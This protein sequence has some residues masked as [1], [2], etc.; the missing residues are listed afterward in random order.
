MGDQKKEYVRNKDLLEEI[1]KSK[2]EDK[3]TDKAV[4]MLMLI[5]TRSNEKLSYRNPMDREDCLQGGIMD[6][7]RYWR[8]F[9]PAKSDQAFAYF[10]QICKFGQA[11]TFNVLHRTEKNGYSVISLDRALVPGFTDSNNYLG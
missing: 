1:I 10:T 2:A 7:L 9:D 5:N 6:C 4:K 8:S 3:L 11:K